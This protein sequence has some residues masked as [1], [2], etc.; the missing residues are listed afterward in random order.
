MN[1][2][3]NKQKVVDHSY[4]AFVTLPGQGSFQWHYSGYCIHTWLTSPGRPWRGETHNQ[5]KGRNKQRQRS[6][7]GSIQSM[8]FSWEPWLVG[9]WCDLGGELCGRS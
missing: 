2:C 9:L 1:I 5:G 3:V 8:P 7:S 6:S 4:G